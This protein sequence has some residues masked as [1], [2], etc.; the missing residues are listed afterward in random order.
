M[1]E[2]SRNLLAPTSSDGGTIFVQG[3]SDPVFRDTWGDGIDWVC[4]HCE[5][6]LLVAD[7]ADDQ[8]WNVEF[9]CNDCQRL[10]ASPRLP[11]GGAL[12]PGYVQTPRGRYLIGKTVDMRRAVLAGEIAQ[13]QRDR[14]AGPKGSLFTAS[15]PR[16]SRTLTAGYLRKSVQNL[17]ELVGEPLDRLLLSDTL[18]RGSATPP[19]HRHPLA[20]AVG[21]VLAIAGALNKPSPEIDPRFVI[22]LDVLHNVLERWGRHPLAPQIHAALLNEYP[23]TLVTLTAA[24]L[25]EDV[26][27]SVVLQATTSGR[28]ADLLL[29]IG[30]R[31][32]AALEIKTPRILRSPSAPID[33]ASALAIIAT[34]VK[35]AGTGA[36]GQLSGREPGLLMLGGFHLSVHDL[37]TLERA[38][39]TYLKSADARNRHRHLL[40]ISVLS[41]GVN[42]QA[43]FDAVGIADN[44]LSGIAHLRIARNAGYRGDITLKTTPGPQ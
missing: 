35:R 21:S 6:S 4:P 37:S 15:K 20:E 30:A 42:L 33:G 14:E 41:V 39:G 7:V 25:L 5:T 31:Q 17:R 26:G 9:E 43:S 16:K 19:R 32:R 40:G 27:N 1:R 28:S 8:L 44:R 29:V 2:R 24:S 34:A 3:S 13:V 36:A 11:A 18:A 12:P 38:A 22:E 23:H 10:S